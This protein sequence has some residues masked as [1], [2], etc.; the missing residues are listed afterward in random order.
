MSKKKKRI[1]LGSGHLYRMD[2]TGTLPTLEEICTEEN[3]F[4]HIKNGGTLEYTKEIHKETDDLGLVSKTVLVA[5]DAK[6]K[7]GLMTFCGETL[8]YLIE[9]ARTTIT[10]DGKRYLTKIGGISQADESSYVWCFH[11]VDKKDGDI[12]VLII[13]KNS[14]GCTIGFKKDSASIID[15]EIASEPC[16]EEGTLI[17]YYEEIKE[18]ATES[19]STT[20]PASNE[21]PTS[22]EE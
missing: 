4:S 9:T 22:T 8:K 6:L 2:F 11:H 13:G 3:R 5:E 14:T 19:T 20:E 18:A 16:D 10:D 1:V 17:Y 7:A 21:E 15:A 12:W